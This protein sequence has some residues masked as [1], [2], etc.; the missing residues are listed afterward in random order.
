M[1]ETTIIRILC[2]CVFLLIATCGM[3]I[4]IAVS[5]DKDSNKHEYQSERKTELLIRANN[6]IEYYQKILDREG[7]DYEQY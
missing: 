4:G 1:D 3:L 2:F 6:A 5:K 7:I